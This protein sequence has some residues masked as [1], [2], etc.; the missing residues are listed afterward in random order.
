VPFDLTWTTEDVYQIEQVI[1][2]TLPQMATQ[3]AEFEAGG[4]DFVGLGAFPELIP[5][6][7][8]DPR[9]NVTSAPSYYYDILVF[10]LED[11]VFKSDPA[12]GKMLR[13][14]I[15]YAIDRESLVE[16]IRGGY[17]VVCDNPLSPANTFYYN[18]DNPVIYRYDI[19]TA[20]LYFDH[21]NIPPTPT[22]SCSAPGPTISCDVPGNESVTVTENVTDIV[23]NTETVEALGLALISTLVILNLVVLTLKKR[24]KV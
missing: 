16:T 24:R 2:R 19:E 18:W 10:N 4:I 12:K 13:K 22:I 20:L 8:A 5:V 7:E 17:A 21:P 15:A 14:A 3:I 11:P 1:V 6:Y 9:F 23:T